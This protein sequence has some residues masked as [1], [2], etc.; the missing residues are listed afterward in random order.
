M[1]DPTLG[2][3]VDTANLDQA[4]KSLDNVTASAQKTAE[5]ADKTS[6]SLS[7]VGV[8]SS[9]S[10]AGVKDL[11]SSANSLNSAMSSGAAAGYAGPLGAIQAAASRAGISVSEFNQR[12]LATREAL[13]T[14]SSA[15]QTS[16]SSLGSLASAFGSTGNAISEQAEKTHASA[17]EH[18][19][20][21]AASK[22]LRETMHT[23]APEL[24][25]LGLK[26]QGLTQFT[27]ASRA[28]IAAF[29]A[30]VAGTVVIEMAKADDVIQTTSTRLQGL[31]GVK[32][33]T[34]LH[35]GLVD[36]S[37]DIGKVAFGLEPA[38]ESIAKLG[39]QMAAS[40]QSVIF[41]G[42]LDGIRVKA[43]DV[44]GALGTLWEKMR[45]GGADEAQATTGLNTFF[46]A[47]QKAG[48]VTG[49]TLRQ[50][51]TVAP[52]AVKDI[53]A[54]ITN[55][56][57]SVTQFEAQLDKVPLSIDGLIAVLMRMQQST[58]DSFDVWKENPKTVVEAVS[59]LKTSFEE[60]WK[61]ASGGNDFSTSVI[62]S[63][64]AVSAE[65]NNLSTKMPAIKDA[66]DIAKQA[67]GSW[68]DLIQQDSSKFSGWNVNVT[69]LVIKPLY[70]IGDAVMAAYGS[71][72]S[73]ATF[74]NNAGSW[75]KP[76]ATA[77]SDGMAS[78]ASAIASFNT[79]GTEQLR[80][81]NDAAIQYLGLG[82]IFD[83]LKTAYGQGN[84]D[85]AAFATAAV[86]S[87]TSVAQ[88][89]L[90]MASTVA[91]ALASSKTALGGSGAQQTATA[92]AQ[93]GSGTPTLQ[94]GAG[95]STG[96]ATGDFSTPGSTG[97]AS[98]SFDAPAAAPA[99]APTAAPDVPAF[100]TG[101]GFTVGGDGGT[102]TTPVSFMATAGEHVDIY[103]GERSDK[104]QTAG[105]QFAPAGQP[106]LGDD[107]K[108]V[109]VLSAHIA[110]DFTTQTDTLE[111]AIKTA[112]DTIASAVSAGNALLTGIQTSLSAATATAV[113][114]T[115]TVT[116]PNAAAGTSSTTPTSTTAAKP[117][118]TGA[119]GFTTASGKGIGDD[120]ETA[121]KKEQAQQ[122]IDQKA[123]D[124]A[125]QA[126]NNQ[127][128]QQAAQ[129]AQQAAKAA[130]TRKP[131]PSN[132]GQTPNQQALDASG[133]PIPGSSTAGLPAP[134]GT[135]AGIGDLGQGATSTGSNP[136]TANTAQ[137][138]MNQQTGAGSG[139]PFGNMA[140]SP[141][142]ASTAQQFMGNQFSE[143][144]TQNAP[145]GQSPFGAAPAGGAG[146]SDLKQGTD[147][148]NQHLS[149]ANKS[150]DDIS[151]SSDEV[152][153]SIADSA[154]QTT[155]SI[156]QSAQQTTQGID[157]T[158][159]QTTQ[160]IQQGAQ[161]DAAATN[162]AAGGIEQATDK[163]A[164]GIE[165]AI[166]AGFDKQTQD[167][168]NNNA[169]PPAPSGD[170]SGGI[171]GGG[172]GGGGAVAASAGAQ[173][174]GSSAF[175]GGGGGF[176]NGGQFIVGGDGGT[177]TTRVSFMAT[178]GEEVTIKPIPGG[179][180]NAGHFA[181]GGSFTVP[182][183]GSSSTVT[184]NA[185]STGRQAAQ[186][187]RNVNIFVQQGVQADTFI[188][189]RAEIQRSMR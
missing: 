2:F 12:T 153:K 136:T 76:F 150:L 59:S 26:M 51:A 104:A 162:S 47:V 50:L 169:A 39:Q 74:F 22:E 62:G 176:A 98:G 188:R 71:L 148:T 181:N 57:L 167:L 96:G 19:A 91:S 107:S 129:A 24:E 84:S 85:I 165:Q 117:A 72:Q 33:G 63:L 146:I 79:D 135:P 122:A 100:A 90:A 133:N 38:I 182:G 123:A 110:D 111:G 185:A 166:S 73:L 134:S 106:I 101:G 164:T 77:I 53:T 92:D 64:K 152:P 145:A 65:M 157:Q 16:S 46:A 128:A 170:T 86:A 34:Q 113:G 132:Y 95:M 20:H 60:L 179:T 161:Q 93:L 118:G 177:D 75:L 139:S 109:D 54:G 35:D 127:I 143:P 28:G 144:S 7:K 121:R 105:S 184:V 114:M 173:L 124:A 168:K 119:G 78:G 154:Q 11:S 138:F 147:K 23:L 99:P 151:K 130:S 29:A 125:Q 5:Q 142:S 126:F 82:P 94:P 52:Q 112:G 178:R 1:S 141:N 183:A 36:L 158:A 97:G 155:R 37:T 58:K 187:A 115:P 87:F 102:D 45:M 116:T 156:D 159:Q 56:T 186:A 180:F 70:S 69:G 9:A 49:D 120:I 174:A 43:G 8:A 131:V 27:G 42:G 44:T 6:E 31:A 108:W 18:V 14:V 61:S 48:G 32:F 172:G 67:A 149:D 175:G 13:N 88:A 83:G 4:S 81:F 171:P 163:S 41:V 68:S 103:H 66:F 55:G 140:G 40:N 160:G 89:A 80:K 189:S 30:A 17:A 137:Q 15:T 21:S 10:A 3:N 25:A